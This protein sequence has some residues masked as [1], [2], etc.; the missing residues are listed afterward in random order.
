MSFEMSDL[1]PRPLSKCFALSKGQ[2]KVELEPTF[3]LSSSFPP[4]AAATA[5]LPEV[6][7]W[8][9]RRLLACQ[10]GYNEQMEIQ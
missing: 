10:T 4:A 9:V 2:S 6:V 1:P 7:R 8:V 5:V 3:S